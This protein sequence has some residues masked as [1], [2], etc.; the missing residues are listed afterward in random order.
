M[1][2]RFGLL[3]FFVG[4]AI[5]HYAFCGFFV[6]S[7]LIASNCNLKCGSNNRACYDVSYSAYCPCS[8]SAHA[9]GKRYSNSPTYGSETGSLHVTYTS[10]VCSTP[11][12]CKKQESLPNRI[13]YASIS[14]EELTTIYLCLPFPGSTCPYYVEA[15][16]VP[17]MYMN[18]VGN[19]CE[20]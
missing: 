4:L 1:K 2:K 13:C 16:G 8:S 18:C 5:I 14:E 9:Q 10:V 17:N 7:R 19:L 20:E 15:D 12:V 11:L 6:E 3:M